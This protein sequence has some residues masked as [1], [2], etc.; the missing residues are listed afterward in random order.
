MIHLPPAE[1]GVFSHVYD[2]SMVVK[3]NG[4]METSNNDELKRTDCE[5][6]KKMGFLRFNFLISIFSWLIS[7]IIPPN[8]RRSLLSDD[9]I[10]EDIRSNKK[11]GDEYDT[12]GD[13][14]RKGGKRKAVLIAVVF[15]LIAIAVLR[16]LQVLGVL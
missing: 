13:V 14:L 6:D 16:G 15:L 1:V 8:D 11:D 7:G 4:D 2:K 5:G 3:R 9:P 10:P 12:I